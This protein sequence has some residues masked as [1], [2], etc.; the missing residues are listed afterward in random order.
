MAKRKKK[1]KKEEKK[2]EHWNEVIGLFLIV[3]SILSI[4]PSPL[5]M[6]GE[7]GASFAM[8]LIGTWYQVLLF[9]VLIL[10]CYIG[11]FLIFSQVDLLDFIF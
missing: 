7:A 9:F 11:N 10:G 6:I 1:K 3:L 5:G 4:V 8:F 2:F